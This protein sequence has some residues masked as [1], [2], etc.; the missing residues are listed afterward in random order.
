MIARGISLANKCQLLFGAAVVLI[1]LAAM[2]GPWT[3]LG[4]IV[5]EAQLESSRQITEL[6]TRSQV[7]D[8]EVLRFLN[9]LDAETAEASPRSLEIRWWPINQ[10]NTSD[11]ES[12]FLAAAKRALLRVAKGDDP[13]TAEI[14][15]NAQQS[16]E[17]EED[18]LDL[19]PQ[20]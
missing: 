14:A 16:I 9:P 8:P 6:W 18:P 19:D 5:D 13:R 12:G 7:V 3:R 4:R 2:V 20:S 15:R 11:P 1:V 17:F 10:W